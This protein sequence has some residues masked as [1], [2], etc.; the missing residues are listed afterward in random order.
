M[1]GV[2]FCR[3]ADSD[4]KKRAVGAF[5]ATSSTSAGP[6]S[7][8][9][10]AGCAYKNDDARV[11][12]ASSQVASPVTVQSRLWG[13]PTAGVLH[14]LSLGEQN[15]SRLENPQKTNAQRWYLAV[16][17]RRFPSFLFFSACFL[18]LF[19][20]FLLSTVIWLAVLCRGVVHKRGCARRSVRQ[21]ITH[22]TNHPRGNLLV[23]LRRGSWCHFFAA[24]DVGGGRVKKKPV[25]LQGKRWKQGL[26]DPNKDREV[27]LSKS[28]EPASWSKNC[29]WVSPCRITVRVCLSSRLLVSPPPVRFADSSLWPA[30]G[31]KQRGS[32]FFFPQN[33][34][35]QVRVRWFWFI[36]W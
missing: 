7:L 17:S 26:S 33:D 6:Y 35:W 18:P 5:A 29:Q 16:F 28:R 8:A 27:A 31:G 9:P 25:R 19:F 21:T 24:M 32:F 22:P 36:S 12:W 13:S 20:L 14:V 10:L 2:L 4:Y 11:S 23:E 15:I 34:Q 3:I 30:E 1:F